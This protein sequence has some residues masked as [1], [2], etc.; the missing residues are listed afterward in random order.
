MQP[1]NPLDRVVL[2]LDEPQ[3]LVNIAGVIR[4]MMNMGLSR[5]RVV[6]PV[7][8]DPW[9]ITGIAHRADPVVDATEHFDT[10]DEALADCVF[11]IGTSARSRTA[12]RNYGYARDWAPQL[13]ARAAEG[14]VAILF[15][16]E[17][18][19]LSN[20]AL[21]RCDGV[22][23]I[24]TDEAYSSLNLAQASLVLAY[25]IFL[26]ARA[27]LPEV[28]QGKRSEG[29]ATRE[30]I[31]TMIGALEGGLDAIGFFHARTAESVM[32]TFRTLLSRADLDQQ[33]AGLIQAMGFEM[34]KRVRRL[35]GEDGEGA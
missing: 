10:L 34:Q 12:Q 28:P 33:E 20:A 27:E 7:E 19:G 15:G 21:D 31:E 18:R 29:P 2:V 26:A 24:P 13:I 5:L 11:V 23:I 4:V 6:Q 9:R 8:W 3:N 16:R 30:R 1:S 17:D 22:A 35:R 32:R 25:E 14:P